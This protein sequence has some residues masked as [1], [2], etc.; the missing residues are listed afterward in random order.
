MVGI[1]LAE[2]IEL[3][4]D[5]YSIPLSSMHVIGHS[6]GAHVAGYA[7]QRLNKLGRITG[8]DPAEPYFQYTL[9]EV[10]LIPAMLNSS[11]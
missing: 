7:G 2:F 8:L 4:R 11:M 9:E 10:R 5:V 3:L 1:V 6:L